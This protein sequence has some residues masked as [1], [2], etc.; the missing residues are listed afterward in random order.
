M[1]IFDAHSDYAIKVYAEHQNGK[2]EVL[3]NL[4]LP[5]LQK[6]E[7]FLETMTVGGDFRLA[8]IDCFIEENILN[9]I[10]AVQT[11]VNDNPDLFTIITNEN[12]L[13]QWQDSKK[14][15]IILAIEGI[16][17]I[18]RKF[19]SLNRYYE[20]GV[21][22]ICLTHNF[23]N[24]FADGCMEASPG[25]LSL[26]G[27]ELIKRLNELKM[28][29]DLSHI[30]EPSFYDA[31]EIYDKIPIA[32]H[33]NVKALCDHKRN[34]AD[35]QIQSIADLKGVIGM[36][37][38]GQFIDRD[39][40]K[41]T[42]DRIIDHIEYIVDLVGINHVGLGPDFVDYL[43]DDVVEYVKKSPKE[44]DINLNSI[45]YI[46]NCNNISEIQNIVKRLVERGYS[47]Y[48]ISKI[49]FENFLRVYRK[50]LG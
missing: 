17:S 13:D 27:I 4:H 48:E 42:I 14:R 40:K 39:H 26:S 12:V 49:S 29:L 38:F 24:V 10:Q 25:G 47:E 2:N 22:S 30:S 33:S 46:N 5:N 7:V 21:R 18:D 15:G 35:K 19:D 45:K 43:M 20:L 31:I 16:N 37:F 23:R 6:G 44:V 50:N 41:V 11:E 1:K 34:L 8:G 32:S 28:I 9:T 36:N 3:K